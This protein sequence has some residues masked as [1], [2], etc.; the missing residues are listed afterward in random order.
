[1][2]LTRQARILD[3]V[4]IG[5][6]LARM[7]E[8]HAPARNAAIVRLSFSAWLR[9]KEIAC[10]RWRMV[11]DSAGRLVPM[12]LLENTASKGDHGGRRI[13]IPTN[14]F[15]ALERLY[16]AEPPRD[17]DAFVMRFRK[18]A[19][20]PVTRAQAV[21]ALFREWYR[22]LGFR[23]CSSHSG[24]RTGA[25]KALRAGMDI[26]QVQILLGHSSIATT[27]RY[28]D[29]D[30]DAQ[31]RIMALTDIRPV[32]AHATLP[33]REVKPLRTAKEKTRVA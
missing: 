23:G 27:Q 12:L 20:D 30:P 7:E 10:I 14:L 6:L 13:P 17:P 5:H 9:A 31:R 32:M 11:M 29:P 16:A 25:T 28:V 1:M 33:D 22:T 24:R 18:H 8:T 26:R 15:V 19:L 2:A 21:Q 3:D 4:Q